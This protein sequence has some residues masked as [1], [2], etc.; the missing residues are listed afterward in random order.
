VVLAAGRPA[1]AEAQREVRWQLEP[2]GFPGQVPVF[3]DVREQGRFVSDLDAPDFEVSIDEFVG[4]EGGRL[5]DSGNA[6]PGAGAQILLLVDISRTYTG[7]FARAQSVLNEIVSRLD[8]ERDRIGL[9]TSPATAPGRDAELAA[10]FTHDGAA[11]RQAIADLAPLP[12]RDKTTSRLCYALDDA[13]RLFPEEKTGR[14]RAVVL[15]SAGIDRGEGRGDCV[16]TALAR[17]KVPLYLVTYRPDRAFRDDRGESR[18][19]ERLEEIA[20][21]TGG[22]S[23]FRRETE[24]ADRRLVDSLWQRVRHLVRFDVEFPCFRPAPATDH[25][26]TLKV[27]GRDAEPLR[28]SAASVLAPIPVV[29]SIAPTST[30]RADV[31][32]GQVDL[33]A[34]GTGFCGSVA[35]VHVWVGDRPASLKSVT[36][37]RVVVTLAEGTPNGGVKV[38][39]RF[40]ESGSS[41]VKLGVVEPARGAEAGGALFVLLALL[42]AVT[43][44]GVVV[45]A[46]RR[47]KLRSSPPPA[48]P[49]DSASAPEPTAPRTAAAQAAVATVKLTP[50]RRAWLERASGEVVPLSEG[51]NAIGRDPGAKIRLDVEG[52]S[53]EHARLE[54]VSAHGALWL[55]DLGST[56]GTLWGRRGARGPGLK[57]IEGRVRVEDHDV[58]VVGGESMTLRCE[59]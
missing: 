48:A 32:D 39:N 50:L 45:L 14:F 8:P 15:V 40:G 46:L 57:R 13:L 59:R 28:F 38:V 23:V 53:R 25:A 7:A 9:A 44:A 56:N 6:S 4:V 55:E 43:L 18:L 11:L 22:E 17:G 24:D 30:S 47:R 54:L 3:V 12:A 1:P 58:L 26:A 31:D 33:T 36:P 42:V 41:T 2:A 35:T 51:F 37:R 16:Q 21:R 34:D 10:P 27:E 19:E 29:A 52:V 5:V 49:A 20:D